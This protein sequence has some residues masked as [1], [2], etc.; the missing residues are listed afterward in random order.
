MEPI[1]FCSMEVKNKAMKKRNFLAFSFA[2]LAVVG[3]AA[4]LIASFSTDKKVS[5]LEAYNDSDFATETELVNG[6]ELAVDISNYSTTDYGASLELKFATGS[7]TL[8]NDTSKYFVLGS[9]DDFVNDVLEFNALDEEERDAMRAEVAEG[10]RETVY[11]EAE[12]YRVKYDVAKVYVP[13]TMSRGIYGYDDVYTGTILSIADFVLP[14][15]S[16]ATEVYIPSEVQT[17]P[18]GAFSLAQGLTD[19]YVEVTEAEKPDEWAEGWNNGATVHWGTL[20]LYADAPLNSE[21]M[22]TTLVE[23]VGSDQINF[24][25]GYF[26]DEANPLPVVVEYQLVG[27]ATKRYQELQKKSTTLKYDAVG[28]GITSYV[29]KLS[30]N[31]DIEKGKEIDPH[32]VVIHNVYKAVKIVTDVT[33]FEP[34]KDGTGKYVAHYIKPVASFSRIN[35]LN[36]F[37][38]VKFNSVSVFSGYTVINSTVDVVNNGEIY[39]EIKP[40][41]YE[42]FKEQLQNGTGRFRFRF[43]SLKNGAKYR[44]EYNDQT[45]YRK[46]ET[47]TGHYIFDGYTNNN[48]SF[49]IQDS[50]LNDPN[51]SG[52]KLQAFGITDMYISVDIVVGTAIYSSTRFE[53]NF[54]TIYFM[55]PHDT[56]KVF[57]A[58]LFMILTVVIY[59]VIAFAVGTFLFFYNKKKYRNDEFRRLKPKQ[60]IKKGIIYWLTSTA[61]VIAIESII[62]RFTV[63][64][65]AIVVYNPVDWLIVVF[66]IATIIIIGYYVKNITVAYKANQQ[67]KKAI[68]LGMVDET[69]DDGTK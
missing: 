20:N 33:T 65:N 7:Q 26:V 16:V 56:N 51:Y 31:I 11:Y 32:S 44:F 43:T 64:K 53:I 18:E 34:E 9:T 4:S 41:Q 59:S 69:A 29:Q 63:L 38:K 19:I 3:I 40:G 66:G 12:L 54:G 60:F 57:D 15:N 68:K 47:P 49:A 61:I 45:V 46:V 13:R 2:A 36:D 25:I 6:D 1:T 14:S 39:K 8:A 35:N 22:Q 23:N 10:T 17:I 28:A 5:K 52:S 55:A 62:F 50:M 30:V 48:I 27:E 21:H 42:L 58:N 37:I 67:R 24:I